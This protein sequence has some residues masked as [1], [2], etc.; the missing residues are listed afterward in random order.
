MTVKKMVR[1][2]DVLRSLDVNFET[3]I[4]KLVG[5]MNDERSKPSEIMG[6]ADK[7]IKLRFA[8]QEAVKKEALDKIELEMKQLTLEEK[9]IKMVA[10]RGLA[11][12]DSTPEQNK[13]HSRIFAPTAEFEITSD[14]IAKEA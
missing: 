3:A 6:S 14:P 4:T 5:I 2:T 10:L 12:P 7:I 8:L 1:N 11:N 13:T 9:Q